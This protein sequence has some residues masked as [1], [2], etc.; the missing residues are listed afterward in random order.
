M[1]TAYETARNNYQA[2]ATEYSDK[3]KQ[4]NDKVNEINDTIKEL[5]PTYVESNWMKTADNKIS[6]D[7]TKFSG[8]QPYVIWVKLVTSS[9]TY[10]DEA[11]YTMTGT[12][13][14]DVSVKSVTLDKTSLSIS[15]GSVDT[16]TATI[17][18]SDATNKSLIWKSDN[19]KVAT[20]SNGKVTGVS[21]GSAIIT[22]STK[23]GDYSA[24]CKVT[25]TKKITTNNPDKKTTKT[26]T[27][28]KTDDTT[29]KLDRLPNA[30]VPYAIVIAIAIIAIVGFIVYKRVK[31]LNF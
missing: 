3:V 6:V 10:Y 11:I 22:V 7:V 8:E 27:P 29:V 23:D 4:Y 21:E 20:V 18:P 17:T 15:E 28:V 14:A 16:L 5:T 9:S 26:E 12:K 30:G 2:K 13:V 24:T 31:Y 1:K 19:E 25:V